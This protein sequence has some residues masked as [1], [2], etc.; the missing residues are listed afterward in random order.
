MC[1]NPDKTTGK[2]G[3]AF[4]RKGNEPTEMAYYFNG[5]VYKCQCG[6]QYLFIANTIP[7]RVEEVEQVEPIDN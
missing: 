7:N 3:V 1:H 5:Q 4:F 6:S 2:N